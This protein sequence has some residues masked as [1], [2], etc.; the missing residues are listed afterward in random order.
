MASR[1][2]I[3]P[4][5]EAWSAPTALRLSLAEACSRPTGLLIV[6]GEEAGRRVEELTANFPLRAFEAAVDQAAAGASIDAAERERVIAPAGG[7]DA[8]AAILALRRLAPDRFALAATLRLVIAQ[9]L[10]PRLCPACRRPEQAFGSAAALLGLD[11][12]SI[13]WTAEGCDDCGGTGTAGEMAVFEAVAVDP[14]MR[15]LIYDGADA[16]M[17]ARHAFLS[18]PNFGSA[19][20]ALAR[21]GKI[22]PE[23]AVRVSRG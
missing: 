17:L 5:A 7:G 11:S 13:L 19:A 15:R 10:A 21:E 3:E 9:R 6:A 14:A 2:R 18:A 1:S 22:G 20:R 16:S 8:I 12:G 23:A 4:E